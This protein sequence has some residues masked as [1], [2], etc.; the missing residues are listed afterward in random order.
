[1]VERYA[2]SIESRLVD[3]VLIEVFTPKNGVPIHHKRRLLINL[4]GGA[5]VSGSRTVSHLESIPIA[6]LGQCRVIS[7]DYRQ[8]P[9]YVFPAATDDILAVYKSLLLEY[10]ADH[11]GVFD[12]SAGAT[13]AAQLM[14]RL[15]A[16]HLPLPAALVMSA[17]AAGPW[18]V[19]DSWATY[20]ALADKY[21]IPTTLDNVYFKGSD[22]CSPLVFPS[23]SDKVMAT[24][25]PTLLASSTQD[26]ALS[27]V[28]LAHTQ[29]TTLG[30]SSE[31]H[32]YDGVGHA[33][34]Y[35]SNLEESR[36]FYQRVVEFVDR[37]LP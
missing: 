25:P 18:D 27:S 8:G 24:F 23:E 32:V 14:A 6:A 28:L 10:G 3:G 37:F 4:H 22:I 30:V 29:L 16:E 17:S 19:G 26:F 13:L 1:M 33:F 36:H 35:N 12:C 9:D 11:I 5:F 20:Q 7:V 15:H 2:V 31:L 21:P 34:L